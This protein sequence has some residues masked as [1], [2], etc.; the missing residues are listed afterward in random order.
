MTRHLPQLLH[1]LAMRGAIDIDD[2]EIDDAIGD[3]RPRLADRTGLERDVSEILD[4][5]AECAATRNVVLHD[6]DRL[7]AGKKC[8]SHAIQRVLLATD[9]RP[10]RSLAKIA[11]ARRC[12]TTEPTRCA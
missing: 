12:P 5:R 6:Q 2:D 8:T 4:A 1:E 3:D 9:V 11:C 10:R 7:H